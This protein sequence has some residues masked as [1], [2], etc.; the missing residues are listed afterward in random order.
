M[1]HTDTDIPVAPQAH[2][3]TSVVP[4]ADPAPQRSVLAAFLLG[5]VASVLFSWRPS[6]WTDEAATI[7][8]ASR[9]LPELVAMAQ[10]ID[11]VH[12]TYYA[13]MHVWTAVFPAEA[14]WLRLPAAVAVGLS[15]AGTYLIARR[16]GLGRA[17]LLAAVVLAVL[18]RSSW[19]GMEAR[20]YA[21]S[22]LWAVAATLV[23][24]RAQQRDVMRPTGRPGLWA[25]GYALL[26][27]LG[28]ATHIY[29]A[30][31]LVAH[32]ISLLLSPR[33]SWRF[34]FTW[35][36]A[37]VGAVLL[38][39]PVVW[40]A[41]H[42]T[43]QLGG[44]DLGPALWIR[45]VLVNQWFLGETPTF[46]TGANSGFE[47]SAGSAWKL[48]SLVLAA[49]CWALV[50]VGLLA[51]R[52]ATPLLVWALPWVVVPTLVIGG[53]AMAVSNLYNPRYFSYATA[54]LALLV[55]HGLSTAVGRL[56][57]LRGDD[58][59]GRH[60]R[61]LVAAAVTAILVAAAPVYVS[62][63]QL[64]A[65]SGTDWV[66]VADFVRERS[67]PG[68]SIYFAP[69]YPITGPTV[70]QTTRGIATAYPDAFAGLS[71]LTL[72]RTPVQEANL[73]GESRLLRD[74]TADLQQVEV[75]WVVRRL[76]Y[77]YGADDDALLAA[78]GLTP[79]RRWTGT[80]D[81]VVEHVRMGS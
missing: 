21:F 59:S 33:T 69:R 9:S 54:G 68:E 2:G 81:E 79:A 3:A 29:V 12:A 42:Q 18:P 76:D 80:L 61:L 13:F 37:G 10:N 71:D 73:T 43:G 52:R 57:A 47:V 70:G 15:C 19:M 25:L 24:V 77:R 27:G 53:Y 1:N 65:K 56:V 23:L 11:A 14:F 28:I 20:P 30:L 39:S 44:G 35:L 6:L 60:R 38:A 48:A 55:A 5:T 64:N 17:A 78:A 36:A 66:Q 46:S 45:N 62:Q 63:R 58:G 51:W 22:S 74:A 40:T 32:G 75:L 67:S 7:S 31:L 72:L 41:V 50:A 26:A 16:L 4:A 8:G 34:R 49:L